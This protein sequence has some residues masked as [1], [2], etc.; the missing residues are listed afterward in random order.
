MNDK[1]KN[2][3]VGGL[4]I[5]GLVTIISSATS[6]TDVTHDTPESHIW[7]FGGITPKGNTWILNKETGEAYFCN[8]LNKKKFKMNSQ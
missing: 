8:A 7:T 2:L 5:F 4:A 3:I 6:N 1:L